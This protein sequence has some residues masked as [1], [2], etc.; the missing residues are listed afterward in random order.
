V[1]QQ[2]EPA[3]PI[4]PHWLHGL[5]QGVDGEG[6]GESG[7]GIGVVGAGV[8]LPLASLD[9]TVTSAQEL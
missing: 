5:P 8:G 3:Q 1:V 2:V 7:V 6:V 4:P 9:P